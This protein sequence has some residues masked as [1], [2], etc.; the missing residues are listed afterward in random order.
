MSA[1]VEARGGRRLATDDGGGPPVDAPYTLLPAMVS[2]YGA[3]HP[4]FVDWVRRL[5]R[6]RAAAN[7][8]NDSEANGLLGGMI[9]RVAALLSVGA[10]R[11][12]FHGLSRCIP[13]LQEGAGQLGRALSEEPEFWRAVPDADCVDWVAN[14]LGLLPGSWDLAE[15]GNV[16]DDHT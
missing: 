9:W 14:E 8:R 11:A 5:L 10:Q 12:I 16:A 13:A 7:S 2:T 6:D 1:F 4:A 15:L 3:W